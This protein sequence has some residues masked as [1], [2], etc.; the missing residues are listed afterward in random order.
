MN[1]IRRLRY[2]LH[3]RRHARDLSEEMDFH[4]SLLEE[5]IRSRGFSA[6]EAQYGARRLMG[7]TTAACEDARR[8]WIS[9]WVESAYQDVRYAVRSLI[10][11][12]SFS[13]MALTA[14]TLGIGLNISLFTAINAVAFRGWPVPES[15]RMVKIYGR[16]P[17]FGTTN[18]LSVMTA[19]LYD[20]HSRTVDGVFV[21]RRYEVT[22]NRESGGPQS[23]ASFV[24]GN[25]FSTLRV[26][27][28]AGRAFGPAEDTLEAPAAVAV[29]SHA[30]WTTRYGSDP[31]IIGRTIHIDDV[32]FT[33][34]GVSNP[35]FRGTSDS[36]THVWAPL[37]SLVLARPNDPSV[38]TMLT[39]PQ[40]CCAEVAARLASGVTRQQAQVELNGMFRNGIEGAGPET[41]DI[42][43]AGTALIEADKERQ[44]APGILLAFAATGSI[45][46]LACA[47]VANL[48]LARSAARQREIAI[49]VAVG[50]A[51]A[52][53]VRQLL[54][55]SILLAATA[56]G[57]GLL[58]AYAVPTMVLRILGQTPPATVMLT[59]D[60]SVLV[61][62]IGAAFLAVTG[63]GLAPALHATRIATSGAR[64]T[65]RLRMRGPLL[66]VQVA[67]S[68]ML[69]I[70]AS[71][72][73]RGVVRAQSLDPGF[74]TAGITAIKV[75]LPVNSYDGSRQSA[76]FDDLLRAFGNDT[77]PA[78]ISALM[79]FG[80]ASNWTE[81]KPAG[82]AAENASV[83][84]QN[85]TAGYFEVLQMPIIAGRNFTATDKA[86]NAIIVNEALARRYWSDQDPVGRQV[87]IGRRVREVVGVVRNSQL[88]RIGRVDPEYFA[89]FSRSVEAFVIIDSRRS[90]AAAAAIRRA[91]PRATIEP[92]SLSEQLNRSLDESRAAAQIAGALGL[93]ALTMATV[94]VYGVVSYSVE[95][96][97]KEIGV[98]MALGAQP[99]EIVRMILGRNGRPILAGLGA[100]AALATAA[101]I[102][103][104]SEL[105]GVSRADPV[106][107]G[108]VLSLLLVA[109]VAASAMP[110][111]RA[112]RTDPAATLRHD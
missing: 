34:I 17:R 33:V 79:P 66:G 90:P 69:L 80:D 10:K 92:V 3:Q 41:L 19:R 77:E 42:E 50:A 31:A 82:R 58:M 43:L 16:H 86:G 15:D 46:L 36:V 98:R 85:V 74:R 5:Q 72:L 78:A 93:L 68:F 103:L 12:P 97:R 111:H 8:V 29:I 14:L 71:L 57:A 4:R 112:A 52:R 26:N 53:V 44:A 27:M 81:F 37:T 100:G 47:N 88:T 89:P 95:Q 6:E 63:F 59:P 67:V 84:V 99:N 23:N 38:R 104:E 76:F 87:T 73:L 45:L 48:L 107:W 83:R 65:D 25:Y 51:R 102:A 20:E 109:G 91:E 9:G 35:E 62:A 60:G 108:G 55:E 105:Y 70:T 32:P 13:M 28:A 40:W 30:L 61:F 18:G 94:G 101:S 1:L 39:S 2:L 106:V 64:V 49:R 54:T 22:L 56:G 75:A 7:N 11:Q 96:R 24:S 21:Q 110:S